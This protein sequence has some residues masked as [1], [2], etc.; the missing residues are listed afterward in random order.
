M[1]RIYNRN[2][3]KELSNIDISIEDLRLVNLDS[4]WKSDMHSS[5]FTRIYIVNS[6]KGTVYTEHGKIELL[7]NKIYIIPS[8]LRFSYECDDYLDKIYIH[9]RALLPDKSDALSA[10]EKCLKFDDTEGLFELVKGFLPPDTAEK[11]VGIK[12]VISKIILLCMQSL[13]QKKVIGYSEYTKGVIEY[14]EHNLSVNLTAKKIAEELFTS[15]AKLR[16]TFKTETGTPLGKYIDERIM[17]RAESSV[18]SGSRSI[19]EISDSL[20]FCDQFYF[21]RCFSRQ[22]GM[23][24]LVYRKTRKL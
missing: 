10:C 4:S 20:G 3:S 17:T 21:S 14:I 18:R 7:P 6:G 11:I 22:F 19:K 13:K 16:K 1:K 9:V 12:A 5:P 2:F 8:G 15:S 23:S 24:P